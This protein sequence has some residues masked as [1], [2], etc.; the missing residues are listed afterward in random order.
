[1]RDVKQQG[2][3]LATAIELAHDLGYWNVTRVQIGKE[4]LIAPSLVGYY[5]PTMEELRDLIV[6]EGISDNDPVIAAQA[7]ITKH[8]LAPAISK[9]LRVAASRTLL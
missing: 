5:Y 1:M 9:R 8:P 3:I 7:I 4:L 2:R 6:A